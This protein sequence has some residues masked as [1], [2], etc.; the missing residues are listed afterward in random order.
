MV[1]SRRCRSALAEAGIEVAVAVVNSARAERR[2][3]ELGGV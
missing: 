2:F 1:T 3:N